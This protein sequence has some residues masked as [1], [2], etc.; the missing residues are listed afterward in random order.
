MARMFGYDSVRDMVL[1]VQD[2]AADIYL[3]REQREGFLG[4]LR[5][6]GM[7]K[8]HLLQLRRR[9]GETI[10]VEVCARGIFD[11]SGELVELEGLVA[12]V[13]ERLRML[14]ELE[15]LARR[16][17]LTGLWN[18]RYFVELGQREMARASREESPLSLVYF[19]ADHFKRI[20]DSHGHAVGD[21]VLREIAA[22]GGSVLRELDIF[23]RLGGEEFAILLP[24]ATGQGAMHVAEKLRAAF[25][26]HSL[27]LPSGVVRFTASFGVSQYCRACPCLESFIK[28]ADKALYEAKRSGRN[29]VVFKP[30][31]ATA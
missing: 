7:L 16:D 28:Y 13:T 4:S 9:G 10:W 26:A 8:D 17:G 14:K 21:M 6:A 29:K 25:E 31:P 23:G 2:I 19:D 27:H 30:I 20:N 11:D 1:G 15:H 3:S 12:D 22:L 24:G 5:Q 18:R